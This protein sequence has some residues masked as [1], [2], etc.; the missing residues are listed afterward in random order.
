MLL[1]YRCVDF[2]V[3]VP[4]IK[5][6]EVNK[7]MKTKEV[8]KQMKTDCCSFKDFPD[9]RMTLQQLWIDKNVT[10]KI[11]LL[12]GGDDLAFVDSRLEELR[13]KDENAG[14]ATYFLG[15]LEADKKKAI[16]RGDWEK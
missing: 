2:S 1:T 13:E 3:L 11:R 4:Q 10:I 6:K 16:R 8:N 5:T 15:L 14:W 7:Q 9:G 12:K